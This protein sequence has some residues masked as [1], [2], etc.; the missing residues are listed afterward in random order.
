MNITLKNLC[1]TREKRRIIDDLSLEFHSGEISVICGGNGSGKTTLLKTISGILK[2]ESGKIRYDGIDIAGIPLKLLARKRA[3]M[4]QTPQVPDSLTVNEL[5]HLSRYAFSDSKNAD[6]AAVMRALRDTGIEDFAGRKLATLSGGELRKTFL[7][8]ALAQEP[9][10]LLLDEIDAG[11]DSR[12]R[13]TFPALLKKLR[14]ERNLTVIMVMHDLD[15]ALHCADRLIGL[16]DGK[17]RLVTANTP[18]AADAINE[19][20]AGTMH[21]S[22]GAGGSLR[23]LPRY[24][25]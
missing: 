17:L 8:M 23:A 22:A 9:E 2:P 16:A 10:L 11:V 20:T 25:K 15:L 6:R 14:C 7:A 21:I 19:F 12:F 13:S 1:I 4:M 5:L 18:D 24:Q 3:I